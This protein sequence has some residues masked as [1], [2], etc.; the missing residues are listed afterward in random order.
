M[1]IKKTIKSL[2]HNGIGVV[3]YCY[4]LDYYDNSQFIVSKEEV[5]TITPEMDT[6]GHS[7]ELVAFCQSVW[8]DEVKAKYNNALAEGQALAGDPA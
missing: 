8:T 1:E 6:A 3:G 4:N 5:G 7:Q 2:S